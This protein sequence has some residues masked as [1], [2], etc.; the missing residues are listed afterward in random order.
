MLPKINRL[1]KKR[2]FEKVFK[3]GK[4]FGKDFL[5]LKLKENNLKESRFGFIISRKISKR[6]VLRNKI[7]RRL[8]EIVKMELKKMK[9]GIDAALIVCPG[10]EKKNFR[11]M[12]E[13]LNKL[14]KKAGIINF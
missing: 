1:T 11:E 9:K 8:S 12:E 7:K 4:R 2:D 10:L 6:A 3:K 14:F 5:V 13:I